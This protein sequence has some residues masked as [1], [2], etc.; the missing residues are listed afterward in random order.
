MESLFSPCTHLCD[1]LLE[2]YGDREEFIDR[3]PELLQELNLD[4]SSKVS[5]R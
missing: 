5:E 4:V 3:H 1:L 2:N